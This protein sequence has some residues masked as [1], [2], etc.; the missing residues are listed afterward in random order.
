VTRH[1]LL[2]ALSMI[3]LRVQR[4]LVSPGKVCIVLILLTVPYAFQRAY[5]DLITLPSTSKPI[6]SHGPPGYSAVSGHTV[7]VFGCTGFLGRYLV[8]KI[9]MLR[10][11]LYAC[12]CGRPD[13]L[14]SQ[15][16]N[17]GHRSVPRRGRS[18]APEA[19][20]RSW[21]DSAYGASAVA[22]MFIVAS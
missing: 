6:V 13:S 7:T 22:C 9:G 8:A 14:P 16:G 4:S 21:P 1:S 3:L 10:P 2:L 15:D 19:Y 12:L 18:A 11:W 5:H 20:G 17:S